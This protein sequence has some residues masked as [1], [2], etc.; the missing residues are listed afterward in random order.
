MENASKA[1]I[2]AGAILLSILLISLGIMIFSQAQDTVTN[3]GMSDAEISAF[4]NRFIKYEGTRKGSVVKTLIQEVIASNANED[5]SNASRTISV[6]LKTKKT[7]GSGGY[8]ESDASESSSGVST[9]K[10]YDV[11]ISN[12]GE[13]TGCVSEITITEK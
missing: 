12:Y 5:N 3:S 10:S 2:I 8:D 6:I 1:L 7:G 4:N 11:A 13:K 9:A